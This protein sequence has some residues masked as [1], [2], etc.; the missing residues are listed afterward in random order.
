MIE[1]NEATFIIPISIESEDRRSNTYTTLKYLFKNL[2]TN[3]LIFE[4]SKTSH[5]EKILS[6]LDF[7]N[8]YVYYKF[9]KNDSNIFHRTKIL[10]EMLNIVNTPITINYDIDILLK[11][12]SYKKTCN[13]ITDGYDL[14]YPYFWGDSQYQVL[15]S[16]RSKILKSQS[17][18]FLT[19]T[20]YKIA[21]SEFGHCQ[22]FNTESYVSGGMENENF[23]S[24]APEDQ[25]RGY[26]F[27][28]LGY[29]VCWSD[30]YVYHLEHTRT[31]NS[32]STNP[33]MKKNIELFEYI[34]SLSKEDLRKYYIN[35]EYIKKYIQS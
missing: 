29:Q 35:S 33:L 25:E 31:S 2:Q 27:R 12:Q 11:P 1:L 13:L 10:N 20:D 28:K 30:D 8:N 21:R 32:N 14:V 24:Y 7:N 16:G 17:L 22:F 15:Y 26:R 3:I 6:E 4:Y 9:I 23:I 18:N 5:V 19:N 34:K